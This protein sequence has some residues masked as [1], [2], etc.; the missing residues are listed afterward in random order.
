MTVG[1]I[2][3]AVN[4]L[5]NP[6][7]EVTGGEPLLQQRCPALLR[8]LVRDGYQVLVETNGSLDISGLPPETICI[9]DVKCPSSGMTE[10]MLLEN[11]DGLR[12]HDEVKF[13]VATRED[14]VWAREFLR[15]LP[16]VPAGRRLFSPARNCLPPPQLAEW[17]LEDRLSVRLQI[18]LHSVLW[19][20]NPRGR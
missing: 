11:L 5:G 15:R 12:E 14:Y 13:V 16:K 9:L 4:S 17:I 6:L 10:H 1:E 8:A 20:E 3:R 18:P 7:V 19:P 2:Q